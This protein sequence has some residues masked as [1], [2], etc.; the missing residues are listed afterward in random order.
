[1]DFAPG[2]SAPACCLA[3]PSSPASPRP[4]LRPDRPPFRLRFG[5]TAAFA[6]DSSNR[7]DTY[8]LLT[9]F[10]DVFERVRAEY[11]EPVT[12][13]DL[14]ENAINGM[15]TGLDPH[16]S[17][18]NAKAFRDMQV[19]TKGEFGGLGIEVTQENGFI[20]VISPID[21]T[22]ASRAGIKAGDMITALDGKTVQG[23]SLNDAVDKMR[24]APN[25]K[26]T[27]TIKREG[28]DKPIEVS[29]LREVIQIQ[30]V[31]QRMEPDDIGY[32][33]LSQFT[34]QADAGTQ[35]GGEDAEA[36]GGRQAE[37]ADPR[38]AQQSGRPAGSGGGGV[39]RLHRPGRDR[40][41]PRPPPR[42]QPALGRQGRRHH[43]RRAA[44]GA[45]Q[46]RLGLVER[47][48][49]RRACRTIAARCCWAP[50]ASARARCRP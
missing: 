36:A 46:R 11:V 10:G 1:M 25:S 35:A 13:K 37:G 6:Q 22:P 39:R 12:D 32:I 42:G 21:D 2:V 44:G 43:R 38:P 49:R 7:A 27:L 48:R 17:Y 41:D 24:G 34:E 28:V 45:D 15:L 40:L 33:R 5:I 20:K 14:V 8:R 9:L 16:S 18:M 23:L 31:K 4:G 19:Q 47:D 29:M 30:V 26:I 50:A 3:P